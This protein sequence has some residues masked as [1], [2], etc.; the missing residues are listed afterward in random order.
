MK[1][2]ADRYLFYNYTVSSDKKS[3]LRTGRVHTHLNLAR[4]ARVLI[5]C[6]W[7]GMQPHGHCEVV[8]AVI[9]ETVA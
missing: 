5:F 6:V 2:P 7:R 3:E 9:T 8:I 1:I 4:P